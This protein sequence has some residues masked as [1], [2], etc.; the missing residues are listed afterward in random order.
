[1]YLL[2]EYTTGPSHYIV[3]AQTEDG[4]KIS[5][6][7]FK[8]SSI[9]ILFLKVTEAFSRNQQYKINRSNLING[10]NLSVM[11]FIKMVV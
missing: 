4:D 7:L 11:R 9:R 2:E 8:D 5:I 10:G 6:E 3:I 1:V